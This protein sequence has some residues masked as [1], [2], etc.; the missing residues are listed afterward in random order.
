MDEH[1]IQALT[2]EEFDE[3]QELVLTD[4]RRRFTLR[5]IPA[6]ITEL[7]QEYRADGGSEEAL[8]AAVA[9]PV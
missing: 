4:Q 9:P 8:T 1:D 7:A 6:D 3:L 5:Q 2:D